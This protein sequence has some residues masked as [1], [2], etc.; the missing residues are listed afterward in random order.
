MDCRK[1]GKGEPGQS[2]DVGTGTPT[3]SESE[4]RWDC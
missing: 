3:N 1:R 4:L 2:H